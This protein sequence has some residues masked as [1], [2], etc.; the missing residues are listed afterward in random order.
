MWKRKHIHIDIRVELNHFVSHRTLTQ[1]HKSIILHLKRKYTKNQMTTE[2]SLFPKLDSMFSIPWMQLQTIRVNS[3]V[4]HQIITEKARFLQAS[5]G[6]VLVYG[7]SSH[8]C[9]IATRNFH[10][11]LATLKYVFLFLTFYGWNSS[12]THPSFWIFFLNI[13]PLCIFLE[14]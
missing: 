2:K 9:P 13:E 8:S 5:A 14:L 3:D 7:K 12:L 1:H 11:P 10:K 6:W 4:W